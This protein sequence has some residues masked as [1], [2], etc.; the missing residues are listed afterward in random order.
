LPANAVWKFPTHQIEFV[1]ITIILSRSNILDMFRTTGTTRVKS[2]LLLEADFVVLL[3]LVGRLE[4]LPR[5]RSSEKVE[6]DIG[7]SLHVVAPPL[8]GKQ[9]P[10]RNS[11]PPNVKSPHTITKSTDRL[12]L[13]ASSNQTRV[14]RGMGRSTRG[15][16][17][18]SFILRFAHKKKL[19]GNHSVRLPPLGP[20]KSRPMTRAALKRQA[21]LWV[22]PAPSPDVC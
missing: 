1:S 13:G 17:R 16:R 20:N 12:Q 21:R 19:K 2:Y 11:S 10:F 3:F 4:T 7:E 8:Q 22:S 6:Q 18:P 15:K 9:S 5:Q 14:S